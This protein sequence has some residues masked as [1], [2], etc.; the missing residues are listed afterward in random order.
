MSERDLLIVGGGELGPIDLRGE[1]DEERERDHIARDATG[2]GGEEGGE[3]AHRAELA[4][5]S[6][7]LARKSAGESW[8][9]L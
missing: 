6:G 2:G 9:A 1:K 5:E 3:A 8:R 4:R 7:A